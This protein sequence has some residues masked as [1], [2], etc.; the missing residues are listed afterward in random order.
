MDLM[1]FKLW[2]FLLSI[3]LIIPGL[4]FLIT[5]G[6]KLG[7]DFTGGALLEYKFSSQINT[8]DLSETLKKGNIEVNQIIASEN[9]TY[10]IK[11]KTIKQ[12][13]LKEVK[14]A[15]S[16]KFGEVEERRIENI[17]PIIGAEVSKKAVVALTLA[18][19]TIILYITFSF[20][21]VPKPT[22]SWRFGIATIIALIHDVLVVVGSFA[23]FG[24][25]FGVEIDTLFI[26]ALLTII[27]F[28]VHDTIVVFDRIRENL[29]K[30][31]GGKF[32]DVVNISVVQTLARS[33]NTSLTLVFVLLAMLLFGGET[34]R[35]FVV[36]M[37]IGVI[38]G[39][40]SSIFNAT[41]VLVLWEEKLGH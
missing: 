9:N 37:L 18:V 24:Y 28:S 12:E 31:V 16:Q 1:K 25:F 2:Y 3:I 13:N 14:G 32:A 21:K 8:Q 10:I 27:G 29:I 30:N 38:S 20:R 36:A 33:L 23:I 19:I 35:W 6:L 26:T 4:F 39:T 5:F 7:I 40:Y 34:L 41:A 15:L 22:S 17:G 11:A